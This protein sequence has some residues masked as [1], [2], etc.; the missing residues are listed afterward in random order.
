VKR[1]EQ[2]KASRAALVDAAAEAFARLGYEATTVAGILDRVGMARGAL[3]HYFPGGKRELFFAVFESVNQDFHQRRDA[4]AGLAS[5][6]ERVRAGVGVFLDV[7]AEADHARI[8]LID[9]PAVVPGQAERGSTYALL[10]AQLAEVAAS[11]GVPP[12]DPDVMAMALYS[13]VRSAGEYVMAAAD[14]SSAKAEAARALDRL[15]DGLRPSS[16][17]VTTDHPGDA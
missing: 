7:C 2:A 15:L 8:L 17:A 5:P 12:F 14:P 3:Y 10:R 13:A 11:P 9:A 16:G 4:V 1:E 6:L